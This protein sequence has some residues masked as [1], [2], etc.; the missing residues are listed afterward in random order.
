MILQACLH[1][2]IM[3]KQIDHIEKTIEEEFSELYQ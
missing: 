3:I 1:N 2:R